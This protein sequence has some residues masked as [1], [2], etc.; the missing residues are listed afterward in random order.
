MTPSEALRLSELL[1]ARLSHEL[2]RPL[3]AIGTGCDLLDAED[4]DFLKEAAALLKESARQATSRLQ[5]YRFAY[6]FARSGSLAGPAPHTLAEG[7]FAG[8][9]IACDYGEAAKARPLDWQKLACDL[10]VVA[11]EGLPRGGRVALSCESG[12]PELEGLGEG[13]AL[14]PEV[15]KALERL[16]PADELGARTA[17]AHF[18]GALAAALGY[19][20]RFAEEG[21]DRF[22]LVALAIS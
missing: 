19:R 16:L 21:R 10:L 18:T 13:A 17:H 11:A 20:L 12:G 14:Q 1:S 9:R 22:R 15:V 5:F 4:A 2:I 3:Q 7:Y 8:T 6:G